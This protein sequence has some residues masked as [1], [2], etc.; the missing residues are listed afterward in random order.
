MIFCSKYKVLTDY[1]QPGAP[2]DWRAGGDEAL[3]HALVRLLGE[4]DLQLPVVGGLVK[5]LEKTSK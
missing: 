1:L 3:V 5:D 4:L 2:P